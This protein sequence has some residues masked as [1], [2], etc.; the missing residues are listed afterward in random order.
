MANVPDHPNGV[1][2]HCELTHELHHDV[3]DVLVL[4]YQNVL[5]M[6]DVLTH[7]CAVFSSL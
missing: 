5:E 7:S 2:A 3:C 4:V 6:A 1:G